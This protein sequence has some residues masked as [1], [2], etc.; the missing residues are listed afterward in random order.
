VCYYCIPTSRFI[1]GY[2]SFD[3]TITC[4]HHLCFTSLIIVT[5]AL[6]A[7]LSWIQNH[8]SWMVGFLS[9]DPFV[10]RDRQIKMV[11]IY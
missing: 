1:N 6:A 8:T 5:L 9:L 4:I 11:F 3:S 7:F 2:L 10:L